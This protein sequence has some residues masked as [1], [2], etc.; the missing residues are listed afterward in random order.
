VESSDNLMQGNFIGVD[1]PGK[2]S[3]PNSGP[4]IWMLNG[5]HFNQV[6]GSESGQGNTI[7]HNTGDGVLLQDQDTTGNLIFGNSIFSND[8]L[9]INLKKADEPI[10]SVTPNDLLDVD[11]GP[12]NLQNFPLVTNLVQA[13]GT[14]TIYGLL[15]SQP[16]NSYLLD[17]YANSASESSGS[18]E[19]QYYL[20][21]TNVTTDASG[22]A[23]FTFTAV[24]TDSNQ[25]VTVTATDQ[26]TNDTSEYSP[27]FGGLMFLFYAVLGS[28]DF[29]VKFT[30]SPGL[31]YRLERSPLTKPITWAPVINATR[32]AGTGNVLTVTDPGGAIEDK[33]FYRL[34]VVP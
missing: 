33:M 31:Y 17:F 24:A 13:G 18:G 4:G 21:Y 2:V 8:G 20:G 12:N 23:R 22:V 6:G 15:N 14:T 26:Q 30:T 11:T 28:E 27:D 16:N 29:L 1:G 19:G 9:G 10:R 7:A 3:L 25:Y 32:I 5:A 34:V